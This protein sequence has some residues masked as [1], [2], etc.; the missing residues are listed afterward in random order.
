MSQ[1]ETLTFEVVRPIE[2]HARIIMAW[3]NDPL[4]LENSY[5]QEPKEWSSFW[6]EFLEEYFVVPELPPLF[7]RDGGR[8]IAFLRFREV[9]YS[10]GRHRRVA[11]VSINVP[12]EERGKGY[13]KA[14]LVSVQSWV[15]MQGFDDLYA[16][17]KEGNTISQKLFLAAGFQ[18]VG[19]ELHHVEETGQSVPIKNYSLSLTDTKET[20]E[21]VFI[22]AEAGSNW[23]MGTRKRDVAMAKALIDAAVDA[24]ADAVKFQTFRPETVYVQNAGQSRYLSDAGIFED[25]VSIFSDL[26]MPYEMLHDLADY[27]KKQK[28]EFMSAAFSEDDFEAV[29]PYVARHK[30]ASYEIGHLR[31]IEHVARCNKPAIISTGAATEEEIAW[32]VDTFMS[33]GGKDLTLLQCTAKYPADDACMDLQ[34]IDWLKRRFRVKVGLSDHSR[35]PLIAPVSAVALGASL[36]EKHFT[37]SNSLP[38][39]D[40]AFAVTP[41]E[42]KSMVR[43]IR[44]AEVMR[45]KRVKTIQ[46]CEKELRS[47]A[48]RG[49]QALHDIKKGDVFHEGRNIAILR[50]GNQKQGIHPKY[51]VEI[52]GKKASKDISAGSGIDFND[53]SRDND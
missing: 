34:V 47:F 48:H 52:E 2:E 13:G 26:S 44:K 53:W 30:V 25:I 18:E 38:G 3:R 32:A 19:R 1:E 36:I 45:G 51:L 9:A 21:K 31:L 46:E 6:K 10:A 37:L 49:V 35:D 23:R 7:V 20:T 8:R 17:V 22:V 12:S 33:N 41:D 27:C 14:C 4:T 15:K 29:D 11:E 28:I 24:G 39:P 50:P 43:A 16:E 42:L 5:H 40:H